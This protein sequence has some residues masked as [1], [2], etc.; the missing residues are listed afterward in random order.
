MLAA[1]DIQILRGDE[2]GNIVNNAGDLDNRIKTLLDGLRGPLDSD[3]GDPPGN[4]PDP[5]YCLLEDDYL[6]SELSI[7]TGP[8]LM[9]PLE[10]TPDPAAWV[11]VRIDVDVRAAEL[12]ML[13]LGL[14]SP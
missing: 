6:I 12:T 5:L 14:A 2:P 10:P 8:L 13:N 9:P 4:L 7:K 3:K 1:L 11:N